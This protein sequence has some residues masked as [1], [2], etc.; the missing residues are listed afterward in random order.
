MPK[1]ATIDSPRTWLI[2][3]GLGFAC[4]C[5]VRINPHNRLHVPQHLRTDLRRVAQLELKGQEL[6]PCPPGGGFPMHP[7]AF[8]PTNV[9]LW[10]FSRSLRR[11]RARAHRELAPGLRD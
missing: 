11:C 10:S 3:C 2:S 6:G 4:M 8:R 1:I 5:Q 9:L 7:F